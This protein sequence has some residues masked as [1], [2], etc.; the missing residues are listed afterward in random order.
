LF[1]CDG[2]LARLVPSEIKVGLV[3]GLIDNSLI[4]LNSNPRSHLT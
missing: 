2:A 3:R 4:R 1:Q